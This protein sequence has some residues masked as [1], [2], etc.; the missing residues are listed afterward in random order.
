MATKIK[1]LKLLQEMRGFSELRRLQP[2]PKNS[3][4]YLMQLRTR[5][6][7]AHRPRRRMVI[8]IDLQDVATLPTAVKI[9]HLKPHEDL[10]H[11]SR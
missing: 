11:V 5:I 4:L 7:E 1:M 6:A 8:T 2:A 9:K 3:A 10:D